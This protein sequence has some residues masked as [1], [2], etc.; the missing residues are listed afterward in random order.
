MFLI[1]ASICF[2]LTFVLLFAGFLYASSSLNSLLCEKGFIYFDHTLTPATEVSSS[3]AAPSTFMNVCTI[4]FLPADSNAT[5]SK[6]TNSDNQTREF[7][8][9]LPDL[10][11]VGRIGESDE[12]KEHALHKAGQVS[13]LFFDHDY[14]VRRI[15]LFNTPHF[16]CRHE[17]TQT[18]AVIVSKPV[19]IPFY[20]EPEERFVSLL[21]VSSLDSIPSFTFRAPPVYEDKYEVLLYNAKTWEIVGRYD[22]FD[23]HEVCSATPALLFV[24]SYR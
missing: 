10:Q 6:T 7:A 20:E 19:V 4:P 24:V 14:C 2:C 5:S 13:P 9:D 11:P 17:P 15:R 8:S 22:G 12:Q 1:I 3:S 23:E 16:V 18:Y 21:L